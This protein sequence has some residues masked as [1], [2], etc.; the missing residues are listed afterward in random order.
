M[1]KLFV[2]LVCLLNASV[3]VAQNTPAVDDLLHRM[4]QLGLEAKALQNP[5]APELPPVVLVPQG[6]SI[7]AA[8][9]K[10]LP[11]TIIE[12]VPGGIY[13]E[14][15]IVSKSSTGLTI[16][17]KD[18]E[19]QDR[20]VQP[21][22]LPAMAT[23]QGA[24]GQSY[25][26]WVMAS[27]TTVRCL[28]FGPNASGQGDML[29]VGD[30][31]SAVLEDTPDGVTVIQN[32]FRGGATGQKRAIAAN[33]SHL[34]IHQNYAEDIWLLG[35]DSQCVAIFST[36]GPV[37]ITRNIFGCASE[38]IIVGGVPPAGPAF[39]PSDIEIAWNVLYK[40]LAWRSS[41][42]QVKNLAEVK[43]GKRIRWHHNYLVNNWVDAQQGVAVL[44]TTATN[45]TCGSWCVMEDVT[46]EDNIVWDVAGGLSISGY[47]PL[48]Q[49]GQGQR[50]KVRNNLWWITKSMGGTS[51]V[52]QIENEPKD[53]D[54]DHNTFIH[55]GSTLVMASY[56]SK[57]IIG[58]PAAVKAGPVQGFRYTNNLARH[59]QPPPSTASYG[60]F[61]PEGNGGVQ[62]GTY[63]PGAVI[64][65]NVFGG[66]TTTQINR[67]NLF[68]GVTPS[69]VTQPWVEFDA[70]VTTTQCP[71]S[72]FTGAGADC[73]TLPWSLKDL[74][75]AS[76]R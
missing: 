55:E 24:A 6:G 72:T 27:N 22:D 9:D 42:H 56:G 2:A 14:S 74:V 20:V 19:L 7:Q 71:R 40:P 49:S 35:Q 13:K 15:V 76:A 47:Y 21:A 67:Y 16:T 64:Q 11:G 37:T 12:L 69:N 34:L 48:P 29:R 65:S 46:F 70:Q 50:F 44:F 23:I 18:C 54:I 25:G 3:A 30:S 1:K 32:Y 60:I 58:D 63:F 73:S 61:T 75:P 39:L 68:S 4:E 45:G 62:L 5:P 36:P 10:A 26:L 31:Q 59:G 66:A 53:V 17:S 38:N 51:R 43:I 41:P 28:S 52:V 8:I 33:G 57:W